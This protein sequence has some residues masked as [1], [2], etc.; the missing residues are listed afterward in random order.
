MGCATSCHGG[1]RKV[2][3]FG[4][5][6]A[7]TVPETKQAPQQQDELAAA[8]EEVKVNADSKLPPSQPADP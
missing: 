8:A 6:L 4:A 1:D 2:R 5:G 7:V 3:E